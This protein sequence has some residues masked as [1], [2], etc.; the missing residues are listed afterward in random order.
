ME[1]LILKKETTKQL[2][3]K[4]QTEQ[5]KEKKG[6]REICQRV[7]FSTESPIKLTFN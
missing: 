3:L 5:V 1:G 7:I 6:V 4:L 2:L